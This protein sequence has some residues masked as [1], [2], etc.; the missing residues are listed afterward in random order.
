[1]ASEADGP[2][3]AEQAARIVEIDME[4]VP[5]LPGGRSVFLAEQQDHLVWLV[6]EGGMTQQAFDE[7]REYLRYMG[8]EGLVTQHWNGKPP[9]GPDGAPNAPE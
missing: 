4:W 3:G 6:A 8:H 2:Q 5:S 1:M 9:P 7:T